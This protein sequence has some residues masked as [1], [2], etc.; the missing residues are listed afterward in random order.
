MTLI[1]SEYD[2]LAAPEGQPTSEVAGKSGN[3]SA[4]RLRFGDCLAEEISV[5]GDGSSLKA[6]VC[7]IPD[8]MAARLREIWMGQFRTL[9]E[10]TMAD[11]HPGNTYATVEVG[12]KVVATVCNSGCAATSNQTYGLIANLPSMGAGERLTG[13]ALAQKRAEEIAERLGGTIRKAATAK[14]QTEWE[15]RPPLRFTYDYAAMNEALAKFG[16]QM[17]AWLTAGGGIPGAPG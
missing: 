8:E 1:S 10:P 9:A 16:D 6:A 13:P 4:A 5:M 3:E 14:T 12:G 15:S 17:P 11:N 2:A 7:K